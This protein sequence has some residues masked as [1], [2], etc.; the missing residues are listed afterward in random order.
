[1]SGLSTEGGI[2]VAVAAAACLLTPTGAELH[3]F[4]PNPLK[5]PAPPMIGSSDPRPPGAAPLPPIGS[6]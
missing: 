1:M 3:R 2:R 6:K 4:I 5:S